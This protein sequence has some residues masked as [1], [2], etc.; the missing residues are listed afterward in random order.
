MLGDK[1]LA[2]F[3]LSPRGLLALVLLGGTTLGFLFVEYSGLVWLCDLARRGA[4]I[5]ALDALRRLIRKAPSLFVLAAIQSAAAVAIALPFALAALAIY[6]WLLGD[7]DINYFLAER[8]P[9][10]WFAVAIG[11][12]L[13]LTLAAILLGLLLRWAF[14]LPACVLE[15]RGPFAALAE[16]ARQTR[17]RFGRLLALFLAWF[18][19]QQL[20]FIGAIWLLDRTGDGV[21]ARYDDQLALAV[22]LTALVLLVDAAL[23]QAIA[24]IFAIVLAAAI[25]IEY[26]KVSPESAGSLPASD[27]GKPARTNWLRA[28]ILALVVA[29][30]LASLG[31][32]LYLARESLYRPPVGITAHRAGPRPAPENSIA[33]LRL[34]EALGVDMVEID[35]L[36]TA[37]GQVVLMHDRDLRRM[38]GDPREVHE[39]TLAELRELTLRGE[40]TPEDLRP[41]TLEE[42][43]AACG[44]KMRI[45]LELKDYGHSQNLAARVIE[46]VRRAGFEKRVVVTSFSL[47]IVAE[48]RRLAP[49]IPAAAIVSASKGDL[50]SLPVDFL[51]LNQSLVNGPLVRRA[52]IRGMEV[53]VW[54]VSTREPTLRF[55]ELGC[56][57]IITDDPA[58]VRKTVDEYESWSELEHML[59]RLRRWMRE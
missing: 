8:P 40:G 34:T 9:R 17:G 4:A 43:I 2:R 50:T 20:I 58:L 18:V 21:L 22:W 45:N 25:T 39:V 7:A 53:H 28:A 14:A 5:R 19:A 32:G 37:D 33:A 11:A 35:L 15:A 31:Y 52:H 12:V 36:L 49:D 27:D 47:P 44:P 59:L 29:G 38:T 41:P 16:S 46:I 3:L 6:R 57:N 56:D 10:F 26:R 48:S 13:G 51:S 23:L 1:E 42:F 55:L 24:A 30:P 54:T